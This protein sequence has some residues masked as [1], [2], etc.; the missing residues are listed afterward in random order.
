MVQVKGSHDDS[1][2]QAML[3]FA[4][5]ESQKILSK[6][7]GSLAPNSNIPVDFYSPMK[8]ELF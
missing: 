8:Q 2:K 3:F 5:L 1:T 4:E 7:S 6:G